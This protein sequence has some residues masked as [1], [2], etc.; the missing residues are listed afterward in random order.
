MSRLVVVSSTK[1]LD[2]QNLFEFELSTVPSSLFNTDSTIRK[3]NKSQLL[4]RR[5][6]SP[7]TSLN[8]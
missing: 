4:S 1:D 2:L 5:P 8:N 6:N 3:C 7:E